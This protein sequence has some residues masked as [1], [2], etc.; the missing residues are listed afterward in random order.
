[1]A[2]FSRLEGAAFTNGKIYFTSTQGGG[3]AET[4]P[5]LVGGYGSGTGQVW[6]YDPRR[7][8]LTCRYQSTS[9]TALELPDNI[10]ARS[11]RGS[12]V[13]CE[14]GPTE[15]YIRR[16]DRDGGLLD[17]ALNQLTSNADPAVTRY[18]EEF[19]GATFSPSGDT[20][21]VNIQAS[22]GVTFAI[23]GPWGRLGI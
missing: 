8:T 10:A 3:V 4:G 6:S 22:R 12:V 15:N 5:D 14:D 19:A 23:W 16:L 11:G 13:I 7:S 21:F 18:G 1:A 2:G 17:I 9:P 20:L